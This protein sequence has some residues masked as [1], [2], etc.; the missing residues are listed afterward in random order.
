MIF[1]KFE[2]YLIIWIEGIEFSRTDTLRPGNFAF[3]VDSRPPCRISCCSLDSIGSH[4]LRPS[5]TCSVNL[6]L[7]AEAVR[8]DAGR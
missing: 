1:M 6:E 5:H 3:N 8:N 4:N 7:S 2:I